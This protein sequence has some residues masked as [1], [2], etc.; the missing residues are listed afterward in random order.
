MGRELSRSVVQPDCHPLGWMFYRHR[1]H[2]TNIVY[3]L[4][5]HLLHNET[6]MEEKLLRLV[7][8]QFIFLW[9]VGFSGLGSLGG[10]F[11]WSQL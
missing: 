10:L 8:K 2:C 3:M 5:D 1:W 11:L 9:N 6:Q 4:I 7:V